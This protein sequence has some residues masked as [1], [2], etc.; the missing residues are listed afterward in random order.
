MAPQDVLAALE[1]ADRTTRWRLI[2]GKNADESMQGG[3]GG[4]LPGALGQLDGALA[5]VYENAAGTGGEGGGKR[6]AGLGASSPKLARWLGDIRRFFPTD[7]VAVVQQDAIERKGLK[8]LLFEKELLAQVEPSIELA[9]T[10]LEAKGL[11]PDET[12]ETAR[13]VVRQVVEQIRKRFEQSIRQSIRGALDRSR[14]TPFPSLSNF[15]ARTTIRRNLRN[16]DAERG[17]LVVE[18]PYFH[19]RKHKQFEWQVIVCLDQSGSMAPSL[20]YGAV[21][22][23]ILASIPALKT[24]M[25]AFDTAVVD[26]TPVVEDPVEVLFG[27]QLGG[28][29]DINRAVAYCS[30]LITNP[31]KTLFILISDL[32]EGGNQ[33]D[34]VQRVGELIQSSVKF[35][36]LLALDDQGAPSFD[37][38]LAKTF[39]ELGSPTFAC[40][41]G[42]LPELLEAAIRGDDLS[43]FG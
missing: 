43:K 34:L 32:C 30:E 8:Q 14:S 7:V 18:R 13:M 16:W 2:L 40:S 20:V 25:V 12:R 37:H 24:H 19:A 1:K 38:A 4:G 3:H 31:R 17:R 39:R 10:L 9:A 27:A 36:S 15:D 22:A 21:M 11:L 5:L 29:T 26:L 41:P 6:G 35:V 28:G 23:S 33:H 42:K